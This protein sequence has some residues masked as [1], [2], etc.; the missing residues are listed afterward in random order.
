M[1]A[2]GGVDWIPGLLVLAVGLVFGT[3]LVWRVWAASRAARGAAASGAETRDL[4]GKRDALLRQLRE[5]EETAGK[6]TPDQLARERY[7]L[8]LQAARVLL[9]LDLRE[10]Q[11]RP[12]VSAPPGVTEGAAAPQVSAARSDA[13]LR[14][15]LWGTGSATALLFLAFFVYQSAKPREEGAAVTGNVPRAGSGGGGP[16]KAT[17]PGGRAARGDSASD[18]E[19][20]AARAALA[21]DP[22]DID[23]H[24]VLARVLLGRQDMMGVWNETKF[25]LE[26]APGNPQAQAYQALVR[27]AMGQ[28]DVALDLLKKALATDPDLIDG[29]VHM[30]LVYVRMGRLDDAKAT[31]A[32]ASQ[33]FPAQAPGLRRLLAD[34]QRPQASRPAASEPAG[35]EADPHAGLGI[36]GGRT[37]GSPGGPASAAGERAPSGRHVAGTIDLDPAL[38]ST[39]TPQ[40]VLFVFVREAG[41]GAGPPIAAKRLSPAAFPVAFDISESDAM[42]GQPFPDSLLVEA[43]LDADGDPTTRPPTDPKA[44][45]DDVKAGSS[46]LHLVLKRP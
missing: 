30:A 25:V 6:R 10:E 34:L 7:D 18:P 45:Q 39:V 15:F 12:P 41:F 14:G 22:N 28:A 4:L 27:L 1:S 29:Y 5:L 11:G 13:G 40:S 32:I 9:T 23:A 46:D 35:D 44:R 33:R 36:P 26:R 19:E 42:M 3:A 17:E 24:L 16:P 31:I 8:E 21:R 2:P 43:R 20:A 38:K 37:P